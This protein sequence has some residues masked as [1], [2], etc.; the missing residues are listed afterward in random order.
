MTH[1]KPNSFILTNKTAPAYLI[2]TGEP[3]S[4]QHWDE[5]MG[6]NKEAQDVGTANEPVLSAVSVDFRRYAYDGH[7]RLE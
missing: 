4:V 1:F 5:N 2:G 7:S 6:W 3:Q